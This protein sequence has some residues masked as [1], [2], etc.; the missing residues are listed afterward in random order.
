MTRRIHS[1]QKIQSNHLNQRL[2]IIKPAMSHTNHK[3]LRSQH[4]L[5]LT[6]NNQSNNTSQHIEHTLSQLLTL[7]QLMNLNQLITHSQFPT[8]NQSLPILN[9]SPSLNQSPTLNQFPTSP[10][11]TPAEETP[12]SQLLTPPK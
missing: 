1:Y 8:L 7:S 9:Q 4:N 11:Q 10:I 12:L 2:S 3:S 5:L 6:F